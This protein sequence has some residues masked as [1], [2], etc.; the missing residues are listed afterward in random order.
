M[1]LREWLILLGLV[2]VAIIVVDGVRRLQ[3]QR[4]VPR[5]DR[6]GTEDSTDD[7]G[8]PA[9]EEEEERDNWEL[10]NG[11]YRVVGDSGAHAEAEEDVVLDNAH[12]IKASRVT[13]PSRPVQPMER[14]EATE[15]KGFG[16]RAAAFGARASQSSGNSSLTDLSFAVTWMSGAGFSERLRCRSTDR[17]SSHFSFNTIAFFKFFDI[18]CKLQYR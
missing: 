16:E 8:N 17:H 18:I 9:V 10:P 1:E 7:A 4:R 15:R 5:L 3:R 13:Q 6:A 2:L 11:G 12:G 14:R